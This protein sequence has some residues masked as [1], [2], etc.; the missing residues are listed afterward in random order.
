MAV[1]SKNIDIYT[2]KYDNLLFLGDFN[3]ELE[4]VSIKKFCLAYSFTS[5]INNLHVTRILKNHPVLI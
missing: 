4:D 2:T 3:M 1:L 5:M